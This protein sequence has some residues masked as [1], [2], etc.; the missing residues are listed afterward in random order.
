MVLE[1]I[2]RAIVA[3]RGITPLWLKRKKKAADPING[4]SAS[5]DAARI[6]AVRRKG[7]RTK[8]NEYAKNDPIIPERTAEANATPIE[9]TIASLPA[10]P[11]NNAQ[12]LPRHDSK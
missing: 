2:P 5:G 3:S 1:S 4:G 10:F 9:F 7:M 12:P 6:A 8:C 11:A